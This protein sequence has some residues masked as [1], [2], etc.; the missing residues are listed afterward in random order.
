MHAK[1]SILYGSSKGQPVEEAVEALPGP[2]A[3]LLP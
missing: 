3:L 2:D 1:D